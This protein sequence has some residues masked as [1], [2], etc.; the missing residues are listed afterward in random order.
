[1]KKIICCMLAACLGLVLA[2]C[3]GQG[4]TVSTNGSTSREKVI[5]ILSEQFMNANGDIT[6]TY[7]A[8]VSGTGIEAVANG[9]CDIGLA[10]RNRK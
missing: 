8:T 9:T 4:E 5:G 2:G 7:A 3:G 10:S 1:M 6:V